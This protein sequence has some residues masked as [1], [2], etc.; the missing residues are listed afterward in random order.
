MDKMKK[1]QALGNR[2]TTTQEGGVAYANTFKEDVQEVFTL[3]LL[4]GN[5]YTSQEEAL[6]H[7]REL[8][9]KALEVCPDF[10]TKCA[11][12]GSTEANLKLIPTIWAVYVSTLDD[13]SLFKSA[14]PRIIRNFNMLYDFMEICRKGGIRKGLGRGIK[15]A[16]NDKFIAMLNEY[17]ATRSKTMLSEIAKA[18]RP[19]CKE[20]GFQKLMKY[21]SYGELAFPRA[22][23]LKTV[24]A[25]LEE[26]TYSV[27][28]DMLVR[29]NN[30][31][32]EE[33]KHALKGLTAKDKER[34]KELNKIKGT[35]FISGKEIEELIILEAK[36][37]K[38]LSVEDKQRLYATIY[39]RLSY[40]SL[41][42]N[43]VALERVYATKSY[44]QNEY[45]RNR[46]TYIMQEKVT[47]TDIPDGVLEM[48]ADRIADEKAYRKSHMLPFALINAERMV[49]TPEFKNAIGKLL[50]IVAQ[51]AFNIDPKKK[52]IVGVDT[53][54][55][56]DSEV[57]PGLS[58]V[59]VA[60][61]FG[62][63][64]K[65]AHTDTKVCA[66]ASFCKEVPV[67][68]Q[69]D[70]FAMSKKIQ[71]TN[72]NHGTEFEKLMGEYDG[73]DYVV[74]ITDNQPADNL[75]ARWLRAKRPNGAKL[76]VW[77]V[78]MSGHKISKDKSVVYIQ[79]YSDKLI[80]LIQNIIEG[81]S[82]QT[83]LIEA[84]NL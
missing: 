42:L 71:D 38:A 13:K 18:T 73:E 51:N 56:M 78:S 65:K 72:V 12:Y 49:V 67:T 43:L 40:T 48:V 81:K 10:A 17:H 76:I 14:F 7:C 30:M 46:G 8:F 62:A 35:P 70:V 29:E 55:S 39:S 34:F 9:E 21:V 27:A 41:I 83:E 57:V 77:Q 63:M 2:I 75:E 79:G 1:V 20:E 3:G 80:G 16:I 68:K 66:I 4:N 58:N 31:Q 54:G 24:I 84:I 60:S 64:V 59:R 69:E 37:S 53:S 44:L 52:L 36:Q 82:N 23:A 50:K 5:F 25:S 15:K 22:I 74:L 61:L 32:L 28:M 19:D 11:I 6:V 26:G 45:N 47:E 33:L